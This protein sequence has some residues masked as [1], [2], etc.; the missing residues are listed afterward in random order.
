MTATKRGNLDSFKMA[1]D[2]PVVINCN[3][4]LIEF[5]V[6]LPTG[7]NISIFRYE[8]IDCSPQVTAAA[9]AAG[10][11]AVQL[12]EVHAANA[13]SDHDK[14]KKQKIVQKI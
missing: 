6:N 14:E 3:R 4:T 2:R 9:L 8:H 11:P 10:R 5:G 7:H 13:A 1:S 12:S